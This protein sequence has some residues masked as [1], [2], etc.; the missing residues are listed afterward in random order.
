M[1]CKTISN[2]EKYSC[3]TEQIRSGSFC[4]CLSAWFPLDP[5]FCTVS[6]HFLINL[7]MNVCY[8]IY[9]SFESPWSI[10]TLAAASS[11]WLDMN[12]WIVKLLLRSF[13]HYR[14]I[15]HDAD[16]M[17]NERLSFIQT[18]FKASASLSKKKKQ[19]RI[20]C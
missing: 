8:Q 18:A 20:C 5:F 19:I 13:N 7:R 9:I 2:Y 16:S 12:L 17:L 15:H 6:I 3:S 4:S 11:T 1:L 14:L 10:M